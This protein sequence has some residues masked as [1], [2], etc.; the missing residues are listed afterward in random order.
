MFIWI[1]IFKLQNHITFNFLTPQKLHVIFYDT[2][3]NFFIFNLDKDLEF[4]V[5]FYAATFRGDVRHKFLM[6]MNK[7]LWTKYISFG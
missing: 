7:R 1:L 5:I 4:F 3:C 6:V 2:F